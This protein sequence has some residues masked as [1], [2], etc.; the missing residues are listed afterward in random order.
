MDQKR[1]RELEQKISTDYG[2][3]T[4][5]AVLKEGKLVY[6]KYFKGCTRESQVHVYSVTKS[7]ISILIGI[8]VDRGYI[9]M[10]R[11]SPVPLA[12]LKK[13]SPNPH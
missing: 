7:I 8:A 4:G 3:T 9:G 13:I 1:I 12:G 6:E 5:V 11:S 2:N 10:F